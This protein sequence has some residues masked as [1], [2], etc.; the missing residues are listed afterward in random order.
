MIKITLFFQT[1]RAGRKP[2]WD[3]ERSVGFS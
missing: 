2:R 3:R 1:S